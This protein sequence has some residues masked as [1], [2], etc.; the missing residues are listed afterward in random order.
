MAT[1]AG[2][3]GR[4]QVL[5]CCSGSCSASRVA[6]TL[7]QVGRHC[8]KPVSSR[9]CRGTS[10]AKAWLSTVYGVG[11]IA[12]DSQQR[13]C[14]CLTVKGFFAVIVGFPETRELRLCSRGSSGIRVGCIG[15]PTRLAGMHG[16]LSRQMPKYGERLAR[17]TRPANALGQRRRSKRP[18]MTIALD[19]ARAAVRGSIRNQHE[20]HLPAV[21]S[22]PRPHARLPGAHEDPRRPRRHQ[23]A[24]RQGPQAPRSVD[25][26]PLAPAH[27][28]PPVAQVRLRT[29]ARL[30]ALFAECSLRRALPAGAP[31]RAAQT[32]DAMLCTDDAPIPDAP[33][34]NSPDGHWLGSVVPK[35]HAARSVTRNMLRRQVRAAMERHVQDLRPGCGW[36]ACASPSRARISSRPIPRRCAALRRPSSTACSRARCSMSPAASGRCAVAAAAAHAAAAGAWLP[37]LLK[38]WLGNACRFEPTCSA[39]ALGALQ[40]H[41]AVVG[42]TLAARRILRCHPWC[43]GGCDPVPAQAPRPVHPLGLGAREPRRSMTDMRRTLLWVVFTMSLVLLWDRWNTHTGQPSMFGG[44]R[45]KPVAASGAAAASTAPCRRPAC[46]AARRRVPAHRRHRLPGAAVPVPPSEKVTITTDVVKATFD[47]Q[48]GAGAP[49]L[50]A[51]RFAATPST[52]S[53]PTQCC[54]T[55]APSACTWRRP[56]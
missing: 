35:R 6:G 30:A 41:G 45:P 29:R 47:S 44:P 53:S 40:Q 22:P 21:Q 1:S 39:Y 19:A 54:S 48:G 25:L 42:A 27:D 2:G 15:Q 14:K 17:R 18:A 4:I 9:D 46:P 24:P 32:P 43:D 23:R 13:R 3:S 55:R 20:A 10:R 51:E 37:A 26:R 33:V 52:P 12:P 50:L 16:Q 5:N 38:P 11:S 8:G 34:D 56:A 49:G 7:P 36:C 28:R 31:R